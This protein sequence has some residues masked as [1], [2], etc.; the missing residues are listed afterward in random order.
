MIFVTNSIVISTMCLSKYYKLVGLLLRKSLWRS[1]KT[2]ASKVLLQKVTNRAKKGNERSITA[3]I[4]IPN[5]LRL[6]FILCDV[7][8]SED[9]EHAFLHM[10][11]SHEG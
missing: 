7:A 9:S 11:I 10:Y 8:V 1:H 4:N 3:T 5:F 2:V 6:A